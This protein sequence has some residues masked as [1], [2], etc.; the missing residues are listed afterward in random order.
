MAEPVGIA[1]A[2]PILRIFSVEKAMAFYLDFLG[3]ALD[4][5]HRFE[6]GMPLYCQITR[7]GL[8]LHLSEHFGDT[9]PGTRIFVPV[10]DARAL[11]AELAGRDFPFMRPG[12]E[13]VPWGLEVTVTDPFANRITFC[14]RND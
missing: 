4:W 14:Q 6:P 11:Q 13:T 12:L 8:T 5:E 9:T 7:E 3:F 2:I 1:G 10:G